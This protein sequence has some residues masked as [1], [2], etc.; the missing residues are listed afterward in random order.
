MIGRMY[1]D[2]R[3]E[4]WD[5]PVS[6]L[7]ANVMVSLVDDGKLTLT[8][9]DIHSPQRTRWRF[10]FNKYPAYRNILEEHRLELWEHLDKTNQRCGN[11]FTVLDSSWIASFR[12]GEPLL[13]IYF[14]TLIHYVIATEDDV[15]EVLSPEPP[16]IEEVG[17][18]P[19]DAP[20]PG[21]SEH[22]YHPRDKERIEQLVRDIRHR[23][24]IADEATTDDRT[25]SSST[26]WFVWD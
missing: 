13:E 6:G 26:A 4:R 14:P 22:L 12:P 18:A 21:K 1:E 11:T 7:R 25:G 15:I 5:T 23:N 2:W 16:R 17:P 10:I 20:P 9:E 3:I 24:S 8:L 19:T